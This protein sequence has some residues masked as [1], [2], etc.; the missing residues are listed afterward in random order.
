[1]CQALHVCISGLVQGVGFRY[2]MYRHAGSLG[3]MGWVRNT[4]DGRVEAL[5]EGEREV[6]ERMLE[7]CR[8]GPV[9]SRVDK[10][11]S[12]WT[13]ATKSF[14]GFEITF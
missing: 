12:T 14:E 9:L 5:V 10:V 11:D 4:P 13:Q 6:L 2:A 3:L 7:W 8:R 1:M